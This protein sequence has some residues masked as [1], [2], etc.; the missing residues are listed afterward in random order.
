MFTSELKIDT[1]L[2]LFQSLFMSRSTGKVYTVAIC[3]AFR[4]LHGM[5]SEFRR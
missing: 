4:V 5:G 1:Y 2:Q 3:E